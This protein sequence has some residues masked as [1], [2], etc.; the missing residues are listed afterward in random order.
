MATVTGYERPATVEEALAWLSSPGAV[1]LGGGTK[2]NATSSATAVVLIDLQALALDRIERLAHGLFTIGAGATLQQLADHPGLPATV[3][4]A[5]RREQP[6]TLRAAATVG[7]CIAHADAESELLAVLLVHDAV[8][9]VVTT[10]G[11]QRLE[12]DA[13]LGNL[14][15]LSGGF[16]VAVEIETTGRDGVSRTARTRADRAIVAAVARR[17][18]DGKTRLALSGVAERPVLVDD[19]DQLEPRGDFRGSAEY[20]RALAITLAARALEAVR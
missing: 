12:L 2:L 1:V 10:A 15:L 5:A 14:D 18:D 3:R 7:G 17:S 13:L 9:S 19:L 8:V 20:R 11:V 6:S 4:E 16:I